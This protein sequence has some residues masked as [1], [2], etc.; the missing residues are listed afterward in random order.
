MNFPEAKHGIKTELCK[1]RPQVRRLLRDHTVL[2]DNEEKREELTER[3][4]ENLRHLCESDLNVDA[5]NE[6]IVQAV[7][8]ST[9]E[10][11]PVVNEVR[12][13]E[14]WADQALEDL[15][16]KLKTCK[17]KDIRQYRK[18]I[19]NRTKWLKNQYYTDLANSINTV[20]DA[21]Q[22]DKEFAMA[23]KYSVLK[24][25]EKTV[26]SKAKLKNHFE[27]HFAA[28]DLEMPEELK[29]PER[30]PHLRDKKISINEDK[31]TDE[32]VEEVLSTFKNNRSAG[33]DKV[34]TESLKYNYSTSLIS[35]LVVLMTLIWTTLTVPGKWL[36]SE[37][38][39]LFKKGS[40][41]LASNYRGISIGTNMSRILCKIIIERMKEA[42]ET[43]ISNCQFGFRINRSTTDDGILKD[44]Y[45]LQC[46]P[47]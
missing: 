39:C 9:E 27:S 11:C 17:E 18:M 23:K 47:T 43:S 44:M 32:E 26:I 1:G 2:R 31:P 14:P 33:T 36:H 40:L 37:V 13:E 35:Y 30:F 7:R 3:L 34:K 45:L 16:A 25:G 41:L 28:Q 8:K 4:E 21:R 15:K 20:A 6:E 46:V 19:K 12:K 24:T 38:T 22:V 29:F 42:Y 5:L 10:V